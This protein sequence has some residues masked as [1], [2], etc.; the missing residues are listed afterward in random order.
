MLVVYGKKRHDWQRFER[1]FGCGCRGRGPTAYGGPAS[2][3]A[4]TTSV[5]ISSGA[6]ASGDSLSSSLLLPFTR[7]KH[8][9]SSKGKMP[10][11]N[12]DRE[13]GHERIL[14]DYIGTPGHPPLY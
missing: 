7:R 13:E 6:D 5:S 11:K 12:R 3:R 8:G 1:R 14:R 10:N 4:S 2:G 9:G